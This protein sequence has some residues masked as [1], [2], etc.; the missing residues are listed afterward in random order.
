[1]KALVLDLFNRLKARAGGSLDGRYTSF[2]AAL[3]ACGG[4]G[5]ETR[6][7]VEVVARKTARLRQELPTRSNRPALPLVES[8]IMLAVARAAIGR[9]NV[10]VLDLGGACGAHMFR[11]RAFFGDSLPLQWTIV[12][13]AEMISAARGH[14]L[15]DGA[16]YFSSFD[17]AIAVAGKPD[18][19]L[20]SGALQYVPDPMAMLDSMLVA[21][22]GHICITRVPVAVS[23]G[24]FYSVQRTRLSNNGPGA[25]PDGI[26]DVWLRYPMAVL[27]GGGLEARLRGSPATWDTLP[28]DGLLHH[29]SAGFIPLK[30]FLGRF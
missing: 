29:S 21:G 26:S 16:R 15:E 19:L 8:W 25:M 9:S 28:D 2:D 7:V 12:E 17:E 24:G 30:T 13:T 22:A 5:Y 4:A 6:S 14:G 10:H 27:D 1:M 11:A 20:C 3:R 23:G 18:L